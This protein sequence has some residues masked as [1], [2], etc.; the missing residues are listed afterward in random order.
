MVDLAPFDEAV[1]P[2]A[3][4]KAIALELKKYDP[5]LCTTNRVGWC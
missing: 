5:E 3:Q 4:A 2:V 1:D